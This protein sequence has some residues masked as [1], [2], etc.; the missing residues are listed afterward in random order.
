MQANSSSVGKELPAK[1]DAP[2]R[3]WESIRTAPLLHAA[4]LIPNLVAVRFLE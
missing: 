4:D 1:N 2:A 3:A